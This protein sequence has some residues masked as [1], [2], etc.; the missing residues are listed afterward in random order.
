MCRRKPLPIT[1]ANRKAYQSFFG[2]ETSEQYLIYYTMDEEADTGYVV[3]IDNEN[4]LNYKDKRDKSTWTEVEVQSFQ[5]CLGKLQ[6]AEASPCNNLRKKQ[7][8][9]FKQILGRAYLQ[10]LEKDFAEV[11][12]VILE[13][14]EY[15]RQR[16]IEAARELFLASAG[17]VALA[18]AI[19]GLTLY[20]LNYCNVWLYGILF[21]IL[22]SFFSI[23]TRYGK[24]EMTGLASK[25]LHYLESIS[26]LFIGAIAAVIVMFAVRSG[27]MLAIGNQ[28]NLFFLYCVLGFAA[29]FSERLV[30]SLIEKIINKQ[31]K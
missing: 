3:F 27:L 19:T 30:P 10:I 8:L 17:S 2:I 1:D 31:T 12:T 14:K 28:G 24:E 4:D 20:F 16:N 15:L 21:G 11:D 5:R 23:W 9:A 25:S 22:G 18:S 26:R 29:G 6:Q 13:A 7:L